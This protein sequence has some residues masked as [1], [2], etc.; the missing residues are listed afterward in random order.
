M[1]LFLDGTHQVPNSFI[2]KKIQI[3]RSVSV[4]DNASIHHGPRA[5][6]GGWMKHTS[7]YVDMGM[8]GIPP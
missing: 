2:C 6:E 8:K 1:D 5:N 7:L 3:S 4:R